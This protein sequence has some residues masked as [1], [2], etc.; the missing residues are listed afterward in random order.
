MMSE[1]S[2]PAAPALQ[3]LDALLCGNDRQHVP[4]PV[5]VVYRLRGLNL[6]DYLDT[7]ERAM[8]VCGKRGQ[9]PVC[10]VLLRDEGGGKVAISVTDW[11]LAA[12]P[13]APAALGIV[14]QDETHLRRAHR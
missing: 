14:V 1:P 2:A 11:R 9:E 8:H 6:W 4:I 5:D 13:A 3:P 12:D 7:P 10:F